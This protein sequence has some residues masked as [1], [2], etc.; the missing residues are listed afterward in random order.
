MSDN[1]YTARVRG[2]GKAVEVYHG[3]AYR[4]TIHESIGVDSVYMSGEE[5][6]INRSDGK[7][8]I[9]TTGG[10]YVRMIH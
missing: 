2:D 5:V 10:S 8:I 9:Y 3:N 4:A 1:T 6:V 7:I